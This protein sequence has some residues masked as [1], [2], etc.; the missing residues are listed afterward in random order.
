MLRE[1]VN[2]LNPYKEAAG[3]RS[4]CPNPSCWR[5]G[6][7]SPPPFTSCP[8]RLSPSG[9][10]SITTTVTSSVLLYLVL[11]LVLLFLTSFHPFLPFYSSS[12][13]SSPYSSTTSSSISF[14]SSSFQPVSPSLSSTPPPPSGLKSNKQGCVSLAWLSTSINQVTKQQQQTQIRQRLSRRGSA[15]R[16]QS[17]RLD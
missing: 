10:L 3:W 16:L 9:H 6:W 2:V 4:P 14:L 8:Q 12:L 11:F 17:G 7:K 15:E 13:F 5:S 1:S